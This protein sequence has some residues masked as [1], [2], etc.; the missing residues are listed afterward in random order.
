MGEFTITLKD[1]K[2]GKTKEI[3]YKDSTIHESPEKEIEFA[4]FMWGEI[5]SI[6]EAQT[7]L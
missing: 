2:T 4:N 7:T 1:K 6:K 3:S 5:D